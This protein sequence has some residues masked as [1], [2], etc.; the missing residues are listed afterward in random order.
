MKIVLQK[1]WSSKVLKVIFLV[2]VAAGFTYFI[3]WTAGFFWTVFFAFALFKIDSKYTGQ[4]ALVCLVC[5]PFLLALNKSD[6][7]EQLAVYA[8]FLLVITVALQILELNRGE[9][10]PILLPFIEKPIQKISYILD[11]RVKRA[12]LDLRT[13]QQTHTRKRHDIY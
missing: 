4:A 7:A 2:I 8:F 9:E 11:L 13:Y 1:A 3:N 10:K 5:L 12:V 6:V